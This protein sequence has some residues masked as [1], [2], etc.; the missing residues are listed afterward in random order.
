[1]RDFYTAYYTA[2]EASRAH[3]QFC[4]EAYGR[5]LQQH[6]FATMDDLAAL[7]RIM[8]WSSCH[9]IL[10]VGCGSGLIAEMISDATGAQ[11]TGMD[12]IPEAVA[13]A[14]ARTCA[15]RARL[16]FFAGDLTRL[17][18][19]PGSFDA[20]LAVDSIYFAT[21]YVATL[22]DWAACVRPGGQM[23]IWYSHGANPENPKARFDRA[24]LPPQRTPLGAALH[25][26]RMSFE[27]W[28]F[29]AS[30]YALAQRKRASLERLRKTFA[31]EGN[32]FLYDNRLGETLGVLDAIESNMHARYL[33][34]VQF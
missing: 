34:R 19:A 12:Y 32:R 20:L 9:S 2:V 18:C 30:D 29:T 33:Y 3:A 21:D 10:E 13:R 1:M 24:T 17:P 5:D 27:T 25:A 31:A 14:A 15:K 23:A 22:C 7:N 8:G 4:R 16:N 6:G 11:I 26:N 28:D